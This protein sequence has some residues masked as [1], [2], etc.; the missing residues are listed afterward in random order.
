MIAVQRQVQFVEEQPKVVEGVVSEWI[1][2]V[3]VVAL[4]SLIFV[5]AF[6]ATVVKTSS[7]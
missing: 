3:I 1:I 6:G 7:K 2:A 4:A 5:I